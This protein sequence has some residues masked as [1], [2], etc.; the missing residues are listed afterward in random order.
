MQTAT[1]TLEPRHW[2]RLLTGLVLAGA[3]M[4]S[5][6]VARADAAVSGLVT[7]TRPGVPM[8]SSDKVITCSAARALGTDDVAFL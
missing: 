2:V 5:P 6:R 3:L 8:G 7:T 1:R 4:T